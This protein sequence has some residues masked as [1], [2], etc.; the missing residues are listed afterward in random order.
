MRSSPWYHQR[1]SESA[2]PNQ[3]PKEPPTISQ[4]QQDEI[5][6]RIS[7]PT[8]S[9][10]YRKSLYWKLDSF[11]DRGF[12]SWSKMDLFDD[13]KRCMWTPDGTIKTNSCKIRPIRT[14]TSS[15][16][17]NFSLP[18]LASSF[19]RRVNTSLD[20]LPATGRTTSR[21]GD[22]ACTSRS[23]VGQSTVNGSGMSGRAESSNMS[24]RPSHLSSGL[25]M[26]GNVSGARYRLHN[27]PTLGHCHINGRS[28]HQ[29]PLKSSSLAVPR[30][31]RAAAS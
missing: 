25:A 12:H 31:A 20:G 9:A 5:T 3:R 7:K 24:K 6:E 11:M 15:S 22:G 10:L 17:L 1:R 8:E 13:C 2:P 23:M 29:Y 4:K 27:K 28:R 18:P 14:S 26:L 19:D 30:V 21:G 16:H